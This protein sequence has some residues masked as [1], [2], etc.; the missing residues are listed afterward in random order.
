MSTRDYIESDYWVDGYVVGPVDVLTPF[1]VSETI[2]SQY[3]NSPTLL[4]LIDCMSQYFDPSTDFGN[5]YDA[6]WNI[7]T[8]NSYGLNVWGKIVNVSRNLT[9]PGT[10]L[11]FGFGEATG[12]QPF[13]QA[14]LY[15][16]VKS[17]QTYVLSDEA[18]RTLILVKAL[19]NISISSAQSI[20]ALLRI[21]F[22]NRGRCYVVDLGGMQMMFTFEFNLHPYEIAILAQSGVIPR[23]AG[24][25]AMAQMV[26]PGSTFGFAEQG[27]QPF[28]QGVFFNPDI[29]IIPVI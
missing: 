28:D 1:D 4:Q 25:S 6:V 2:A 17:T 9:L 27:G 22:Q 18:Y 5:F 7:D 13:D 8:A 21:L 12:C 11:Y 15:D 19:S 26:D 23:P 3:A 29:G 24:V 20:N 16:G 14:P 10:L